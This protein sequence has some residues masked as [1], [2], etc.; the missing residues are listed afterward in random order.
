MDMTVL[1]K[2]RPEDCQRVSHVL[3]RIGDKWSVLIVVL[4]RDGPRRFNDI[5]RHVAGISQQMLTRVLRGLERDGMLTRTVYPTV[6]PQVEYGLTK[7]GRSL[8]EPVLALGLW[9]QHHIDDI[10]AAQAK[11][12]QKQH[13]AQQKRKG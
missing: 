12:D 5:K 2:H 10:D 8:A 6:P 13:A 11:F 3:A 4:L 9:A 1:G 7:M